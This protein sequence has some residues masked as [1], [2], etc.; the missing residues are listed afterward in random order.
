MY[1]VIIVLFRCCKLKYFQMFFEF[2]FI[3]FFPVLFL[4][5]FGCNDSSVRY[6]NCQDSSFCRRF[7][8]WKALS[9][10][11][12]LT[13]ESVS[14][15]QSD[16][17]DIFEL[18]LRL[19][20][21]HESTPNY[22]ASIQCYRNDGIVRVRI[23]DAR[24]NPIKK[25]HRIP[26]G[27]VVVNR[28]SRENGCPYNTEVDAACHEEVDYLGLWEEKFDDFKDSKPFGP[29]AV[30][31]DITMVNAVSM[32]GIP[33]H[34]T[35]F[36]LP[37]SEE[38]ASSEAFRLFGIELVDY[39]PNN[40]I[41]RYGSVG[42]SL[43][44][45]TGGSA[46]GFLWLNPSDTFVTLS[47]KSKDILTTWVS[48][49]G[50]LDAFFFVGGDTPTK[51]MQQYH[52]VTGLPTMFPAFALG[53]HQSHWGW[54]SQSVVSDINSQ[55][56]QLDIPMD[57]LWLDI[58]HTDGKRYF[59]WGTDYMDPVGLTKTI[60]ED[61]RKLVAIVD[62]H[63]KVDSEYPVYNEAYEG[64]FFV[65]KSRDSGDP[66]VGK[67]WPGMSSWI[68]FSRNEA[69]AWWASRFAYDK[70][71]GSSK[72]LFIWNDMNEPA[73]FGGPEAG[74]P[75]D[76][77]QG[78][79]GN[80]IENREIRN[81][82]GHYQH[83]ATYEG[84]LARDQGERRPFV[85]SR[86]FFT[87][88]HRFTSVWTGDVKASWEDLKVSL[89]QV[90]SLAMGGMSFV[91]ADVG[92][93][94]GVPS[95][96]L[97]VRWHQLGSLVYPFYRGHSSIN[98][99]DREPWSFDDEVTNLVRNAIKTRYS[100]LPYYYS[101]LHEYVSLGFPMIRPLWFQFIND[102][103]T[104]IE[105]IATEEEVMIGDSLL[106]RG[107]FNEGETE[108]DVYLP[109]TKDTLWYNFNDK[110]ATA[111]HG[112]QTVSVD[113]SLQTIPVYVKGGSI[114]PMKL[115]ERSSTEGMKDDPI[116]LMVYPNSQGKAT[117]LLYLDDGETT[118]HEAGEYVAVSI[119][120]E[121]GGITYQKIAGDWDF[122]DSVIKEAIVIF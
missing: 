65:R 12:T 48:E 116:S 11:P 53:Y 33:Q 30:G 15:I 17:P 117:G 83:R 95:R 58:Q 47:R 118:A 21:S 34:S 107:V 28:D 39:A 29:S 64:G 70:Y 72:Y 27:D 85:L 60:V 90:Q 18:E 120:F 5:F 55:F 3:L 110:T 106:I 19:K 96:E 42:M 35:P 51:V 84:L 100:L 89:A 81:M 38:G 24:I 109:G 46:S 22:I 2:S 43:S 112:G 20:S 86:S 98:V 14:T 63:I 61:G 75:R 4:S 66:F 121:N 93:F 82:Y 99:E 80:P 9:E 104:Y 41:G 67:C 102:P 73:V 7:E 76:T 31:V 44:V 57:V 25:R 16:Q 79:L 37:L 105:S 52:Y 45:H 113:V 88:S 40:R 115:T 69:R 78:P 68:D 74:I 87:G 94:E 10:R 26:D 71:L 62:P 122:D 13:V 108:V 103:N 6:R 23:D 111:N 97:F 92:G 59:T 119:Y 114:V 56:N 1:I 8:D 91:G 36:N 77:V 54:E 49:T 50:I 32:F 101:V